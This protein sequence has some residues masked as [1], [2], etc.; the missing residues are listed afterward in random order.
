LNSDE[1]VGRFQ[2]TLL[3]FAI[4]YRQA[5]FYY[6][7]QLQRFCLSNQIHRSDFDRR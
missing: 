2:R 5:A 4:Q 1:G 3:Y 7:Q 6:W